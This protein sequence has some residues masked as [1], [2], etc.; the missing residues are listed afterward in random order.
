MGGGGGWILR[1]L[2]LTVHTALFKIN[3]Q[4]GHTVEHTELCV[5][6]WGEG[7][8]GEKGCAYMKG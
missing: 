2:A 5:T 7:C 4:R 8:F 1:E 6:A 3:D